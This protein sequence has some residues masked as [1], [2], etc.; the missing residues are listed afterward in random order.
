MAD[1]TKKIVN[2][3]TDVDYEKPPE[4][5]I[6]RTV[7]ASSGSVGGA[8]VSRTQTEAGQSSSAIGTCSQKNEEKFYVG[9]LV[10]A[11]IIL[12]QLRQKTGADEYGIWIGSTGEYLKYSTASG[13]RLFGSGIEIQDAGGD[14]AFKVTVDGVDR[15]DVLIGELTSGN[16]VHWDASLAKLIIQGILQAGEVH[17]PD[18]DT[19]DDSFHVESNGDTY[20]GCTQTDWNASHDNAKG[21]ILSSGD[22][23]LNNA[24]IRGVLKSSV[25]QKDVISAV[26]GTL[27]VANA[28]TLDADMTALDA[29]TVTIKSG[30]S[31][32]LNQIVRMKDGVDDEWLRITDITGAPTYVATRDLAGAYAAD[33]N[34]AWKEG[35]AIVA[36][37]VSDGAAAYSGGWLSLFGEGTHSPYYSVYAR[38][39]VN[40]N[41]YEERVRLGNL[42]G[43]AG[44]AADAY[45]VFIGDYAANKYFLYDDNSGDLEINGFLNGLWGFGGSGEDGALTIGA[46]ATT[47]LNLGQIYNYSSISINATGTLAFTGSGH[48]AILNCSGNCTIAGTIEL[49]NKED[50]KIAV[51]TTRDN[52]ETGTGQAT[53]PAGEGGVGGAGGAAGGGSFGGDGGDGGDSDAVSGTPGAGGAAGVNPGDDG[54]DGS[55]GNSSVG[56]GGG[57]G[58]RANVAGAGATAGATT[59]TDDGGAGGNGEAGGWG[60]GG[61]GGGAGGGGW[62]TGDGGAGGVGGNFQGNNVEQGGKGG[63]SGNSGSNGGN[64]GAGGSSGRS[65]TGASSAVVGGA[66]GHGYTNGGVGGAGGDGGSPGGAGG[67]GGDGLHGT[68]GTGGQ[69]GGSTSGFGGDGGTGGRGGDGRTGGVGGKGGTENGGGASIGGVGGRGGDGM[70]GSTC[71]ALYVAG[72]MNLNGMTVNAHGGAGGDGGQGGDDASDGGDGGNGGDG[73]DIIMLSLGALSG[74]YTVNNTGGVAGAGGS[75]SAAGGGVDGVSG[76]DGI[77]GEQIITQ[78]LQT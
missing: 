27:M 2:P 34:P 38:T 18:V 71:L 22:A 26:G 75:K 3:F 64:G 29:S 72:T 63:A 11:L 66:G 33:S 28:G 55:G 30:T 56:G 15:G 10:D 42:N 13:L 76:N 50:T 49:R 65:Y 48:G 25:F 59:A 47:T 45:G 7:E 46:G 17:I 57:G 23:V 35:Q 70:Y 36:Q 41:N 20:W 8:S 60:S 61:G 43:I 40:Y 16:Y 68:G 78:L 73:A 77:D 62:D 69:G 14:N 5:D 6:A 39:G 1:Q 51:A 52:L 24:T 21:Y 19:T 12:G 54:D 58:G 67:R 9:S 53:V 44:I 4:Q 74:T 37:G 31:F 32:V